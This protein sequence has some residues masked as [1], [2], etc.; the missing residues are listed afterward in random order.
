MTGTP[1]SA[2]VRAQE[3]S[4]FPR[5]LDLPYP[6]IERGEGVRLYTADGHELIDACSG[7]AMVAA[8]GHGRP[9]LIAAANAQARRIPYVYDHHFTNDAKERLADRVLDVAAPEMARVRFSSGGAEANETALRL[10]RSYHFDRGDGGRTR[11]I[12]F[13]QA[14]HG[15]TFATLSLNG[16][17]G[18]HEA[19]EPYL[20]PHLHIPPSTWRFDPSGEAT[21]AALDRALEEA[22]PDTVAAFYCEPVSAMALPAHR[23]PDRFWEGLADRRERHGFLVCFDEIVSGMGRTGTWFTYQQLPIEPDIVTAGKALGCGYAPLS[24]TLCANHVYETLESG[25]RVFDLGHTWDGAPLPC[26]VGL[27]AIDY[28]VEHELVKR[29]RERGPQLRDELSSALLGLSIVRAVRGQGFLLG[30]ELVDPRD[31]QRPLPDELR[32]AELVDDVAF[33]HGVLVSSS[34][35]QLDGYTGDETLLAP[36]YTATDHELEQMIGRLAE[37]LKDVERRIARELG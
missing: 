37:A 22:G 36:A 32:A 7:G 9:E 17:R 19:F 5:L 34:H 4:V 2:R 10:A 6:L 23:E 26:A 13:A 18:V 11:I 3:T 25:S 28:I 12:S 24:A 21:L 27:A 20:F 33:E 1:G 8:L 15:A 16:R 30:V 31:G 35:S 29:V 14:Y